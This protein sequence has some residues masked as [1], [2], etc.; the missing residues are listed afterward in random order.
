MIDFK[1]FRQQ[2]I[3]GFHHVAISILWKVSA[4]P[5]ARLARLAV[6]DTVGKNNKITSGIEKL[7]RPKQLSGELSAKEIAAIA[8]R[9]MKNQ[10]CIF[11]HPFFVALRSAESA[12]VQLQLRQR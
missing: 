1:T 2:A 10:D 12:V 11:H 3:L 4:Q 7:P 9:A 5:V 6:A 8:S